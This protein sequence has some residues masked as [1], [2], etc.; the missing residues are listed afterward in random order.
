[1]GKPRDLLPASAGGKRSEGTIGMKDKSGFTF[2]EILIAMLI[3]SILSGVV[4]LSLYQYVRKAKVEAARAQ[5][6]TLQTALQMYRVAHGQLPTQEQGLAALCMPP[7]SAPVPE[8]YPEE[9]YLERRTVPDDP[10]GRPYV[11]LIP[12]R[13]NEAFEILCYGGDGEEGGTGEATDISS[14]TL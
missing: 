7:T 3:I 9:G 8:N 4:G 2:L 11:Y 12:G 14:A 1:V 6:K 13:N 10:W 5:I